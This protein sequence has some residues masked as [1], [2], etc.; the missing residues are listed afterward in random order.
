MSKRSGKA[1]REIIT[2]KTSKAD[3]DITLK[4]GENISSDPLTV[5]QTF[6]VYFSAVADK[7]RSKVSP[8]RHVIGP[9]SIPYSILNCVT[10]SLSNILCEIINL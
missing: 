6:N 2:L 3:P 4:I 10:D 5:A 8:T 9:S 7:I 1:I